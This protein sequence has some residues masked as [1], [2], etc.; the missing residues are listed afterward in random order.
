MSGKQLCGLTRASSMGELY[1]SPIGV[2]QIRL[3]D[4]ATNSSGFLSTSRYRY[5]G[6]RSCFK[7]RNDD[8]RM[9][10]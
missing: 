9:M 1:G 7:I 3:C 10:S 5:G 2:I 8:P 4:F 6:V